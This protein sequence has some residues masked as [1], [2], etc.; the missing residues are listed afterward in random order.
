[1]TLSGVRLDLG[2]GAYQSIDVAS[3]LLAV[4]SLVIPE[5]GADSDAGDNDIIFEITDLDLGDADD[6]GEGKEGAVAG[7][8]LRSG[9]IACFGGAIL[10]V[11]SDGSRTM[12]GGAAALGIGDG[13]LRGIYSGSEG[14]RIGL[15]LTVRTLISPTGVP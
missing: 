10:P 4:P 1:M 9:P 14:K 2:T 15:P 7:A 13:P 11:P 8:C 12:S 3:E 6:I 5:S